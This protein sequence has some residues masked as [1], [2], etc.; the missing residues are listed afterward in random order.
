MDQLEKSGFVIDNCPLCHGFWLDSGELEHMLARRA[1]GDPD[2]A[3]IA[4]TLERMSRT[5]VHAFGEA[6]LACPRCAGMLGK[7]SFVRGDTTVIAD[8]CAACGGI[9]LQSGEMGLLFALVE[10]TRRGSGVAGP[11]PHPRHGFGLGELALM[12][13]AALAVGALLAFL[14]GVFR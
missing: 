3:E 7:I 2:L 12:V 8:K 1:S 5:E 6:V 10:R 13:V 4:P 11:G 14:L 9:W